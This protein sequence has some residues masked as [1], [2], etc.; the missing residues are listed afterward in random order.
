M[1]SPLAQALA[2]QNSVQPAQSGVAPT[3]VVGAYKLA[4]DAAEKNYLAKLA[5]NNA[6]YGGL[7]GLGGAGIAAFGP[8][9][10][11][12]LFGTPAVLKPG[13]PAMPG[14]LSS[15]FGAG[16][17]APA[18]G[19]A[20]AAPGAGAALAPTPSG[21]AMAWPFGW[22]GS[23]LGGAGADSIAALGTDAA[24]PATGSVLADLGAAV[25]AAGSVA[26]DLGLG[27]L[28]AAGAA[29]AT[30]LAAAAVPEWLASMLPFLA[31]A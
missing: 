2:F 12:S 8:S 11:N 28:G 24:A 4:S 21:T 23:T 1:V 16:S 30:D 15:W 29:G 26:G 9:V 20:T 17:T 5:A 22:G 7:A 10:K 19:A 27:G 14:L 13:D 18:T 3:D 31:L 6:M 25:P